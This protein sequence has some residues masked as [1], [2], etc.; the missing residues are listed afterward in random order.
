MSRPTASE[1]LMAA[2][3]CQAV[4]P[5]CAVVNEGHIGSFLASISAFTNCCLETVPPNRLENALRDIEHAAQAEPPPQQKNMLAL[6]AWIRAEMDCARQ[7]IANS[8]QG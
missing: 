7:T 4:K 8:P 3:M 5:S 2:L 1:T 6:C